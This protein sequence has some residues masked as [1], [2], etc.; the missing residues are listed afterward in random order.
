MITLDISP[1]RMTDEQFLRLCSV[2]RDLR[3]ERTAEG[4]MLVMPPA[5]S[6]TG[7]RNLHISAQLWN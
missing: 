5:G 2:N 7:K 6:E 3:L 4:E 1:L